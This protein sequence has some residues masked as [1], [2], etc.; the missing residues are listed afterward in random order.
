[1]AGFF[2]STCGVSV[3]GTPALIFN[4]VLPK[5]KLIIKTMFNGLNKNDV[6]LFNSLNRKR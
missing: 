6:K 5:L 4:A 3:A 1:M 2:Q